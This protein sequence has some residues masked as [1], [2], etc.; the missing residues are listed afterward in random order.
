MRCYRQALLP[1]GVVVDWAAIARPADRRLTSMD[2]I[3]RRGVTRAARPLSLS[4]RLAILSGR[5]SLLRVAIADPPHMCA[6]SLRALLLL[7]RTMSD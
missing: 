1:V 3:I 2:L 4:S 5:S 7:A 6:L